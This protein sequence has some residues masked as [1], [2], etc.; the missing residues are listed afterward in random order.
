MASNK[1]ILEAQ[2]YNR[3]RLVAAFSSGTPGGKE[4]ESTS[5][6]QP[7]MAGGAIAAVLLIIAAVMG[8]FSPTL[9]QDWQDSTMIVVTSSGERYY[10]INGRLRPV[11]NITSAKLLTE[12]SKYRT[13]TVDA[14]RIAGVERGSQVGVVG[15]PDDVPDSDRLA[16]DDWTSCALA[17]G[18]HTWVAGS[19]TGMT[20]AASVLVSNADQTYLVMDGARYLVDTTGSLGP[21]RALG[22]DRI[23]PV[24]VD[25]DWLDLFVKGSALASSELEI[26]GAG[27]TAKD[28]PDR[29]STARIGTIID[30]R[31]DDEAVGR[32]YIITGDGRI[33]TLSA[34][35]RR[36]YE[37][38]DSSRAA[39]NPLTATVSDIQ[40]LRDDGA[41]GPADWPAVVDAESAM[42]TD[43]APCAS[44]DLSSGSAGVDLLSI[45]PLS[46]VAQADGS[47]D[48]AGA[49]SGAGR[50][51]AD[52][53]PSSPVTVRGGSG[54]LVRATSGG[55][56]GATI[57]VSDLG[58]AHGLGED[59]SDSIAR[60][61][62]SAEDVV[63]VP[64]AWTKLVEAGEDMTA[65]AAWATVAKR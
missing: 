63:L 41:F 38:T 3:R 44:L 55:T 15:I 48:E 59:P 33:A 27:T 20:R 57:F 6:V 16:S 62:W 58:R 36:L 51:A 23:D 32:S 61:G 2:R 12:P 37:L 22:L 31:E 42:P 21:M 30:V 5:G 4:I 17:S 39:G 47:A 46:A 45:D 64:S 65:D 26:P 14:D 50:S 25:S 13:S 11:A 28:M 29:L 35:A 9:P 54:A 56:L 7:L 8:R 34:T 24:G 43:A 1:D 18:T 49:Q 40:D 10:T 60:L 53:A 52:A 19:P